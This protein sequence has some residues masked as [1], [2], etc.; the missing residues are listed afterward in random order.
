M[1]INGTVGCVS[2]FVWWQSNWELGKDLLCNACDYLSGMIIKKIAT[3]LLMARLG[4]FLF[5]FW[6]Q[7]KWELGIVQ[8]QK[9]S[10][11]FVL[12]MVHFFFKTMLLSDTHIWP[13]RKCIG[14]GEIWWK[15]KSLMLY[16]VMVFKTIQTNWTHVKI[17]IY[18]YIYIVVGLFTSS[19]DN[20]SFNREQFLK[21]SQAV[22]LVVLKCSKVYLPHLIWY[23]RDESNDMVRTS[24]E[25][26]S[27]WPPCL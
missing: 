25:P 16:I 10:P 3:W 27:I 5:F 12:S 15:C 9:V 1:I 13:L 2:I 24:K 18:I 6:W 8:S 23:V 19:R 7:S 21:N 14:N 11:L 20:I 26:N 22:V 4:V 17:N